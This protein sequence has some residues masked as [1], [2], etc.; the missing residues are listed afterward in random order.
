M[1]DEKKI[2]VL[3]PCFNEEKTIRKVIDK[4]KTWDTKDLELIEC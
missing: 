4:I 3:I 2:A 1:K